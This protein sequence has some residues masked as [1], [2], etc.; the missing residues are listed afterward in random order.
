VR[1]SQ[2]VHADRG[3]IGPCR[4]LL[5]P[6]QNMRDATTEMRMATTS[7]QATTLVQCVSTRPWLEYPGCDEPGGCH[8]LTLGKIYE[9]L[10]VEG[11]GSFYRIVDDSGEDFLYPVSH[12]RLV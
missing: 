10:G 4:A 6:T 9:M 7:W 11:K 8:D 2:R 12:F 3:T 5:K 1:A